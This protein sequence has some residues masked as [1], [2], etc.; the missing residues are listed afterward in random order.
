MK[1]KIIIYSL[2]I[3]SLF[4]LSGCSTN[5]ETQSLTSL[6]NQVKRVENVVTTSSKDD[7]SSISPATSL[8][9][10]NNSIIQSHRANSYNNMT[11]ENQIKEDVLALN[12]T[13]KSCLKS[14]LKIGKTKA[15]AIKTLSSYI[16]KDLSKYNE[17]KNQVKNS[18][19]NIKQ[20][21]KVP[22]I[23]VIGAESEY[24][25]LNG[26]MNE[27][28]VYLCNI[29]DNLEQAYF[30]ICDCCEKVP[31][32]NQENLSLQSQTE[33]KSTNKSFKFK[34]NIDSYTTNNSQNKDT[35]SQKNTER[36]EDQK[37]IQSRRN[38]DTFNNYIPPHPNNNFHNIPYGYGYNQPYAYNGYAYNRYGANGYG[39][40][41]PNR[42]TDTFYPYN[43]NIDTYRTYPNYN[44][45]VNSVVVNNM[46]DKIEDK[47]VE[48]KN[49]VINIQTNKDLSKIA[50][51]EEAHKIIK[52]ETQPK[53]LEEKFSRINNR[54]TNNDFSE[55][56]EYKKQGE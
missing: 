3:L 48:N 23:N 30:L 40:Y 22:N 54:E 20:S 32:Q 7:I 24:I 53:T 4:M 17:T 6:Q 52:E 15:K 50:P 2:S 13:L 14:D 29:Y 26:N 11:R 5:S 28:Y 39:R 41:N 46:E 33:E 21:L 18:V 49:N 44:P 36:T 34:K 56:K 51:P 42:N 43:R 1:N 8:P 25:A 31:T 37:V 19:K 35:E 16:S 12:S 55:N 47:V 10:S 9:N 45:P 38:T 27:R